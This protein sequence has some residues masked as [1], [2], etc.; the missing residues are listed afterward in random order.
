MSLQ[1]W[2]I[3]SFTDSFKTLFRLG[4]KL[5]NIFMSVSLNHSLNL[6][7]AYR[8]FSVRPVLCVSLRDETYNIVTS[9]GT[10]FIGGAKIDKLIGNI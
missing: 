1:G 6:F 4:T 7:I 8:F 3:E 9:F 10:I 2:V 5:P